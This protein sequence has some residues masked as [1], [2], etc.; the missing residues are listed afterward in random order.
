MR[1]IAAKVDKFKVNK[2]TPTAFKSPDDIVL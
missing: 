1:V 2:G